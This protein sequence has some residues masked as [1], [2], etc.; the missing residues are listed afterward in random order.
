V[1]FWFGMQSYY[2]SIQQAPR[3]AL[4]NTHNRRC[5]YQ[6]RHDQPQICTC[7]PQGLSLFIARC[8]KARRYFAIAGLVSLAFLPPKSVAQQKNEISGVIGHTFISDQGVQGTNFF[9]Q[10]VHFGNGGSIEV[11]Y[12]RHLVGHR[13]T[14]LTFEVPLLVNADEDLNFYQ[15][16]VPEGYRSYFL[17][18]S[19]QA[20]FL[21]DT[22]ISPWVSLGGGFAY[23]SP[24][25]SL[26]FG[27]PSP[28]TTG[29]DTGALQVGGGMDVRVWRRFR[30][31]A[32]VRDY[33]TGVPHLNVNTGKSHQHNYFVGVGGVWQF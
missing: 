33:Y 13:H 28:K 21:A 23:F 19:L 7:Y 22:V 32:E 2:L 26:L 4:Q 14:T 20:N 6:T 5:L 1:G 29:N 24:S 17:T 8:E 10:A 30:V 16:V 11:S 3:P 9:G 15:N 31:R 25:S 12:G 18:P 27:G